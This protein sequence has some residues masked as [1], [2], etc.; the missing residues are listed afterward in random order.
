[1]RIPTFEQVLDCTDGRIGLNIHVYDI[2]PDGRTVKGVCDQLFKRGIVDISYLALG[3]EAA[4]QCACAYA[5]EID[6]ACLAIAKQYDC[7]RIQFFRDVTRQHIQHA[8]DLGLICNLFWSDEPAD[9]MAYVDN[10]IDVILTNCA[11]VMIA[12]GFNSALTCGDEL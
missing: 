8:H 12:G 4:M 2:G 11:C 9:A 6:R 10:G 5:P 1:M 7:R 3:T